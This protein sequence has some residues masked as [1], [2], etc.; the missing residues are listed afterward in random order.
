MSSR[1]PSSRLLVSLRVRA[2]PA[3][4]FEVF[5]RDIGV[6]WQPNDL[7][8]FKAEPGRLAFEEGEGGR[9]T[10]TMASGE[11]FEIG[12]ITAWEPGSRLAFTWRQASFAPGQETRV[13]V[14]FEALGEE[15][16]VTVEHHGWDSIPPEH[17]ARHGFPDGIFMR[18]HAEWWQALLTA[19]RR[20]I[21]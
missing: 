15:T 20:R 9:F 7:F 14:R 10:E 2:T 1:A 11:F 4:A 17:V 16:R 3:H 8:R 18:R 21:S 12:R 6:W 13:E 5:T 19:Y